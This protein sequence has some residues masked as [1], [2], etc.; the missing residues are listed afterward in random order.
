MN[1]CGSYMTKFKKIKDF[2]VLFNIFLKIKKMAS[3]RRK[4]KTRHKIKNVVQNK[5]KR[6][7]N[8]RERMMLTRKI[9]KI[10]NFGSRSSV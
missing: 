1:N 6:N 2:F 5:V 7:I 9:C 4:N 10:R 3:N 8:K